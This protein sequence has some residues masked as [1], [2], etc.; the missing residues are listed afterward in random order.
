MSVGKSKKAEDAAAQSRS[1]AE[2]QVRFGNGAAQR[3]FEQAAMLTREQFDRASKTLFRTYEE[4]SEL[5]K[6]NIDAFVKSGTIVAKGF[7]EAGKAW[8]DFTRRSFETSVETAKAVMGAKD[9]R[10]VVDVQSDFARTS[11]DSLVNEGSKL[12]ELG[13]KVANEALEP[14]QSRINVTV[15]KILKPAQV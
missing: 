5:S 13:V 10:E 8:I 7:E 1:S 4:F 15:E 11:F 12:S 9:L 2:D 6:E 3:G 14:I